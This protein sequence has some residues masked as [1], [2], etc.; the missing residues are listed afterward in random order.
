[1][2]RANRL[3]HCQYALLRKLRNHPN[4]VPLEDWPKPTVL[5]REPRGRRLGNDA[6][7]RA[8]GPTGGFLRSA[9]TA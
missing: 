5:R 3:N 6:I 4:G 8:T 1:M 7:S 2:R 9:G